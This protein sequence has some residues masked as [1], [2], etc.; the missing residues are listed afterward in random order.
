MNQGK[1]TVQ[2]RLKTP[3]TMEAN[4]ASPSSG[5][6]SQRN[7]MGD[8]LAE[9][10]KMSM[11]LNK[12]V[13]DVSMIKSDTAELKN[14]VSAL[15]TWFKEAESRIADVEDSNVSMVNEKKVL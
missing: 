13:S 1:R 5:E 2:T 10:A 6:A 8:I 12:A 15:Q 9:T 7:N 4:P 3:A 14:A 11:T